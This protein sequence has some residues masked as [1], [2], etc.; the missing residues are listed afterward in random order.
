MN[1][2]F[3]LWLGQTNVLVRRCFRS[4]KKLGYH[5]IIYC[6]LTFHDSYIDQYDLRDYRD[7]MNGNPKEILPFSDLWRYK[8]LYR[9]GGIWLDADMYLLKR[10]P[11]DEIIISSER[12][13]QT[14]AYKRAF[15]S[16]PNI[17][18]LKFPKED[19]LLAMVIKKIET[20][21][22]KST[23]S[24]KNM[25]HF[26]KILDKSFPEYYKY[27][28]DPSDYCPVNW[29]NCK[30]MY[31]GIEFKS[32][33]GKEVQQIEEILDTSI[34]IHLWDNFT[35]NKFQIKFNKVKDGS[36]FSMLK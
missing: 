26:Q 5:I 18:V 8:R 24:V 20:S 12:C 17:G 29:S 6:D 31:Y 30:E 4:W 10:L 1:T 33:Y 25:Q 7:V 36:L 34:G 23:K 3:T 22:S 28:A 32:K 15:K 21:K 16:I 2:V 9:E 19:P 11:E 35:M 14:G 27:V 13:C